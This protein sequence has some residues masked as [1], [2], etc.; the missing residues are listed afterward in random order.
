VKG[1]LTGQPDDQLKT[2]DGSSTDIQSEPIRAVVNIESPRPF[3]NARDVVDLSVC[4]KGAAPVLRVGVFPEMKSDEPAA[5]VACRILPLAVLSWNC[6]PPNN[7][8][9]TA[10]TPCSWPSIPAHFEVPAYRLAA[11]TIPSM[12]WSIF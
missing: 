2:S 6:T 9:P 11:A 10:S 4:G 3:A 1:K 5:C 7:R 8:R 12:S